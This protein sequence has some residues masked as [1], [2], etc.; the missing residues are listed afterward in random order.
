MAI[1]M[2]DKN[3][4]KRYRSRAGALVSK[5]QTNWDGM[6]DVL[7][8][9]YYRK[10]EMFT[11]STSTEGTFINDGTALAS[12]GT[13]AVRLCASALLGAIWRGSE[14]T[15]EYVRPQYIEDSIAVQEYFTKFNTKMAQF[16][17]AP[18]ANA[19]ASFF[20]FVWEWL[21]FGN[22]ATSALSTG[23]PRQPFFFKTLPLIGVYPVFHPKGYLKEVF[24]VSKFT[25]QEL[26]D[27]YGQE[28]LGATINQSIANDTSGAYLDTYI[29]ICECIEPRGDT[30]RFKFD[31]DTFEFKPLDGYLGMDF[32]SVV[33]LMDDDHVIVE[34]GYS[35]M[36]VTY[37]R[38]FHL[39]GEWL[40]RSIAMDAL[41]SV[42]SC[43]VAAEMRAMSAELGVIPAFWST[44]AATTQSG[45]VDMTSGA[46]N[47][48]DTMGGLTQQP[49]VPIHVP[50]NGQELALLYADMTKEILE[51]FYIDK[52]YDLT[53]TQRQTLGEANIRNQMR[54]DGTTPLHVSLLQTY[55]TPLLQR[56]V[57]VAFSSGALGIPE[58]DDRE[59]SLRAK[60]VEIF[61]IP[62]AVIDAMNKGLD[63]YNVEFVC[64]A[65]R[66]LHLDELEG[67]MQAVGLFGQIGQALPDVLSWPDPD[68]V[69]HMIPRVTGAPRKMLRS[70]EAFQQNLDERKAAAQNAAA[71]AADK[72]AAETEMM[73]AQAKS[74]LMGQATNAGRAQAQNMETMG[75]TI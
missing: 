8:R 1:D 57:N 25:V 33:F 19:F 31:A 32:R 22:A 50:T 11:S 62:P 52:L 46:N 14:S 17:D 56:A 60:G 20:E 3:T 27:L 21:V 10:S 43:A 44:S 65:A 35:G 59:V 24:V 2:M 45:I 73:R 47:V 26:I 40:G 64:P 7:A 72:E 49:I 30:D 12:V 68:T 29:K 4:A 69:A 61:Y 37:C 34:R 66:A 53:N 39:P 41:P 18:E 63:F 48:F 70:Q 5:R 28:N 38:C 58:G 71:R 36:P 74:M 16:T 75:L 42:R 13:R 55:F 9:H 15:L 51:H 6:F 23:D 54:L 67:T